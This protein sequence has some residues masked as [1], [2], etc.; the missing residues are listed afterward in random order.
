MLLWSQNSV[1]SVVTAVQAAQ[2]AI[3][4]PPDATEFSP[5]KNVHQ[6]WSLNAYQRFFPCS[7]MNLGMKLAVHLHVVPQLGTSGAIPPL[8][9]Y[10]LIVWTAKLPS[11]FTYTLTSR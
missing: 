10:A 3:Q 6:F 8:P 2:S 5:L 1:V 7:Q 4:I 11:P 9:M